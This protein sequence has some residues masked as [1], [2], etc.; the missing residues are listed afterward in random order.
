MHSPTA[1][2]RR[3]C[4]A[5]E[6]VPDL[7]LQG[8][9]VIPQLLVLAVS[10][11]GV[12]FFSSSESS[13]I[14]VNKIRVR[15]LAQQGG[16]AAQ[17]VLRIMEKH[18]SFFGT[19][20][21]TENALIIFASSVGTALAIQLLGS[22]PGA[23]L[24]ATLV[25]TVLIVSLGEI[26]PKTIAL[27]GAE[28]WSLVVAHPV[29]LVMKLE[30]F[31]VYLFTLLPRA[32]VRLMGGPRAF[33]SPFVTEAEI[34]MLIDIGEAEGMVEK[35]AADMLDNVFR[36]GRRQLREIMTPRP[37]IVWIQKGASLSQFLGV[38]AQHR[39]TRFPVYDGEMD[40]VVGVLSAKD[41]LTAMAQGAIE[42]EGPVTTLMRPAFFV[43]ETKN[44]DDLLTEMGSLRIPLALAVDEFGIISGVVTMKQ[45]AGQ[46]VGHYTEEEVPA[47][48]FKAIDERTTQISGG[49]RIQEANERLKLALPDG[50]YET[51][52]GF[53]LSSLGHIPR[54]G[55]QVRHDTLRLIVQEMKG[56]RIDKVLVVRS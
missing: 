56:V 17:A 46:I 9:G 25:M 11:F 54:E 50:D 47:Q 29:E 34:R 32:I 15:N 37:A 55:E 40:N 24:A 2:P 28:R 3:G 41:V 49:M 43:P 33:H 1:W 12:A 31:I 44:L 38:Y 42:A 22:S 48:G 52:A 39:Y 27:R 5:V 4:S 8:Q 19:I 13:L 20:L 30:R 53:I 36:L 21:L 26:T 35:G 45:V 51:V 23:V 10:I 18:D 6:G 14:S 16:K 7:F